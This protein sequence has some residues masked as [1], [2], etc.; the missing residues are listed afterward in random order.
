MASKPVLKDGRRAEGNGKA[1]GLTTLHVL[2]DATAKLCHEGCHLF[3]RCSQQDP[4]ATPV[5][6]AG[7]LL[8]ALPL[9][10]H[11]AVGSSALANPLPGN[12]TK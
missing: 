2:Y 5:E 10:D 7:L 1:E 12:Y 11:V 8:P 4:V 6:R 3:W 9:R